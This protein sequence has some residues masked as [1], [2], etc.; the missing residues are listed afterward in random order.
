MSIHFSES[1]FLHMR[2][3]EFIT[4]LENVTV[5]ETETHT[6]EC[7]VTGNPAPVISWYK[8]EQCVDQVPD[9][10]TSFNN[11]VCRLTIEETFMEDDARYTCRAVNPAGE[12]ATSAK[13]TVLAKRKPQVPPRFTQHLQ[14]QVI[15]ENN[16]LMFEARVT[17]DPT[18]EVQWYKNEIP[19]VA[20]PNIQVHTFHFQ[21]ATFN[22]NRLSALSWFF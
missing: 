2:P 5:N 11:G 7:N 18:P 14:S 1:P 3:P 8:N 4:K 13:L 16:R 15:T 21:L 9:Y 17:G 19:I 6:F 20:G 22:G 12:A 10:R